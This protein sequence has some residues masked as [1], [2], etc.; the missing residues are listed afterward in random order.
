MVDIG[1]I[2]GRFQVFHKGHL[3]YAIEAKKRCK[4]L[5]VG[6][7]NYDE[8]TFSYEGTAPHRNQKIANPLNYYERYKM[9][10]AILSKE[11]SLRYNYMIVPF[12]LHQPRLI[13]E[14]VP[15]DAVVYMTLFDQWSIEKRKKIE[16]ANYKVEVLWS[17]MENERLITASKIRKS[18]SCG[19]EWQQY[20]PI[21]GV[22]YMLQAN[23]VEKIKSNGNYN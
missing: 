1:V 22:E 16:S 17:D 2:V 21:E 12:P 18:I 5:V 20:V 23:I 4:Y 9:I 14:Y 11:P 13:R 8:S 10:E 15:Q 6:V 19:E 3:E 7:T